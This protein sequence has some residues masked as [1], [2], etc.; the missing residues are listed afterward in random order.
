MAVTFKNSG[1]LSA[2]TANTPFSSDKLTLS[3][4]VRINS[5]PAG[6]QY[7]A[8]SG[9]LF[10]AALTSPDRTRY[11]IRAY[12]A[13]VLGGGSVAAAMPDLRPD[14]VYHVALVYDAADASRRFLVV[15]TDKIPLSLSGP[16]LV[17]FNGVKYGEGTIDDVTLQH[18]FFLG[19][20][21]ATDE[22]LSMLADDVSATPGIV[23]AA[24]SKPGVLPI[25]H[26]LEGV[27]GTD[28][29]AGSPGI[30]W[31][32]PPAFNAIPGTS[33]PGG[34]VQYV[35]PMECRAALQVRRAYIGSS[36]K[37]LTVSMGDWA[38]KFFAPA[39]GGVLNAAPSIRIDGGP[40]IA[41]PTTAA[42][43]AYAQPNADAVFLALPAGVSIAKGQQV[44]LDAPAGWF[45]A[46]ACHTPA[47]AGYP[48]ANYS[49]MPISDG[50]WPDAKPI[51]V[52][53]NN[54]GP[55]RM[56]PVRPFTNIAK[57]LTTPETP[58]WPDGTYRGNLSTMLV[59]TGVG[60]G[61]DIPGFAGRSGMWVLRWDD[62]DPACP[63]TLNLYASGSTMRELPEYRNEGDAQGRGKVRVY[64]LELD[65]KWHFT[66]PSAVNASTT[67][68]PYA[69]TED[70]QSFEASRI[71]YITI[72]DESIKVD[73]RNFSAKRFES[74]TR[75]WNGTTA[76]SYPAG[77]P[78][79]VQWAVKYATITFQSTSPEPE[80]THYTNLGIYEVDPSELPA[81]RE[82][83]TFEYPLRD[84]LEVSK[85]FRQYSEPGAG[86]F[87][88]MSETPAMTDDTEEPEQYVLPDAPHFSGRKFARKY[89]VASVEPF[90]VRKSPYFYTPT[91][92]PTAEKY[93]AI[94]GQSITSAPPPGTV[95][96]ITLT[97]GR[98]TPVIK[99]QSLFVGQ[100]IMRVVGV[101]LSGDSYEVERGA[102]GSPTSTHPAGEIEVGY[103]IPIIT[104]SQFITTAGRHYY[105]ATIDETLSSPVEFGNVAYN[106]WDGSADANVTARR[107]LT[108]TAPLDTT[109]RNIFAAPANPGDW[110]FIA[111][112]LRLTIGSETLVV[113]EVD[114]AAGRVAVQTRPSSARSYPTG[115]PVKTKSAGL[116]LRS[117]DGSKKAYNGLFHTSTTVLATGVNRAMI[118]TSDESTGLGGASTAAGPQTFDSVNAKTKAVDFPVQK[119][120]YEFTARETAT[121][122]GAWHWLNVPWRG[123]DAAVYAAA[124]AVRDNLPADPKRKIIFELGNELW[125]ANFIAHTGMFTIGA[126]C[127]LPSARDMYIVRSKSA[128]EVARRCFAEVGR[129]D[130]LLLSICWQSSV[131]VLADCRRLG[132]EPDVV[133]MAPYIMPK[134]AM[135]AYTA[136]F[137]AVDDDQACDLF[138]FYMFYVTDPG[139]LRG[140]GN[141]VR[142]SLDAHMAATGKRPIPATYEGGL[143]KVVGVDSSD[144]TNPK[145]RR[146]RDVV[147]SPSFYFTERDSFAAMR[148]VV[149]VELY[150]QLALGGTAGTAFWT[151]LWGPSQR[152]G[153]GD[154]RNGGVNN[155]NYSSMSSTDLL[156]GGG[157]GVRESVRMQAWLD[158][159]AAWRAANAGDTTPGD[160]DP[161]PNPNPNPD[162]GPNPEFPTIIIA[163]PQRFVASRFR[164]R[165]R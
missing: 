78:Y 89:H 120:P 34:T 116:L 92:W 123:T 74:C 95:Q 105:E 39:R 147:H 59:N 77:T 108:L 68:I 56:M 113:T 31:A 94:L 119:H 128:Y 126:A 51:R 156:Q 11:T 159:Q 101:P 109:A 112:G 32:G 29:Q 93:A 64:A 53:T 141:V 17:T 18:A 118:V 149:N 96:S 36:G 25:Y 140:I 131:D 47:V 50:L 7:I 9:D 139:T 70:I 153:Y 67:I 98:A 3:L 146:T 15:N 154:G 63:T 117:P 13:N 60:N 158:H 4:Y 133:A 45:S 61:I 83:E 81:L 99:G 8:R 46:A 76:K 49:G 21:A 107:T 160:P 136:T 91:P 85:D 1:R 72:G 57:Y 24:A 6:L 134:A 145:L 125:N 22:E 132:V 30:T 142:S 33:K 130:E 84:P 65:K 162:P 138:T 14:V 35:E 144:V 121:S 58:R 102:C 164:P 82:G 62:Y 86:A 79:T 127:H 103:R 19:G 150:V 87:R 44:I 157:D 20:H 41:L 28:V 106:S 137:D 27:A 37:T 88:Y 155:R 71:A 104:T 55:G 161:D 75:G 66:L 12:T 110:E 111:K 122:P 54:E 114:P 97:N 26:R 124:K 143:E 43:G 115:T 40:P 152:P 2:T 163:R 80:N 165:F 16:P 69:T 38:G 148:E 151:M 10:L 23:A 42:T 90:D 129:E 100:E 135:T 73:S 52:G 5:L 48:V